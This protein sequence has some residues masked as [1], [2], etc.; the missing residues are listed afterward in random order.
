MPVSLIARI[1]LRAPP[2]RT[3]ESNY[4]I[5]G[6]VELY[7]R[8]PEMCAGA[9]V[10]RQPPPFSC[11]GEFELVSHIVVTEP[12][13]A[14]DWSARHGDPNSGLYH[15]PDDSGSPTLAALGVYTNALS[16]R[17]YCV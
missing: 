12:G 14:T 10:C 2:S 13:V 3:E 17:L 16:T 1:A 7:A 11:S 5:V 6:T 9:R 4:F 15:Y 8:V